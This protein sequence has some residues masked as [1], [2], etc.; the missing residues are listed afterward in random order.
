LL[1]ESHAKAQW[2]VSSLFPFGLPPL[3]SIWTP[4]QPGL[5][6]RMQEARSRPR[7]PSPPPLHTDFR[8]FE[9]ICEV[10]GHRD[11]FR[12][13]IRRT[14]RDGCGLSQREAQE[15]AE[16]ADSYVDLAVVMSAGALLKYAPG[17]WKLG[18]A[19]LCA[20]FPDRAKRGAAWHFP[21][22]IINRLLPTPRR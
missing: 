18:S 17:W 12:T 9:R 6:R 1:K 21:N 20:A 16:T 11:G 5:R 4:M 19:A 8:K 15:W 13:V 10:N 3:A 22:L 14:L 2:R 7:A